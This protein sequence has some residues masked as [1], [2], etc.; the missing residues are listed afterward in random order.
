MLEAA[1]Q[2]PMRE[3]L[4]RLTQRLLVLRSHD[5]LYEPTG[6]VREVLPAARVTELQQNAI[7][8][9]ACA[10]QGIAEAAREFLRS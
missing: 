4:A 10:P 6:R 7:E 5:E 8:I 9:L 1:A 3:R 2:Y